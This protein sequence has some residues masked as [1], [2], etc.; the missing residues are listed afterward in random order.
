MPDSIPRHVILSQRNATQPK[1]FF[2][3]RVSRRRVEDAAASQSQAGVVVRTLH[4]LSRSTSAPRLVRGNGARTRRWAGSDRK[5]SS[6]REL[7]TSG[8]VWFARR[9]RYEGSRKRAD[10][11]RKHRGG[12]SATRRLFYLLRSDELKFRRRFLRKAVDLQPPFNVES[13]RLIPPIFAAAAARG[14]S[15]SAAGTTSLLFYLGPL[16]DGCS[17]CAAFCMPLCQRRYLPPRT[18]TARPG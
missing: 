10:L 4:W 7:G 16:D 8:T 3:E 12:T 9:T 13:D 11:G 15:T 2:A 14:S 18:V 17:P 5:Q 1:P 6:G